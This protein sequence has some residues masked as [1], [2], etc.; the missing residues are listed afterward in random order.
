V[1]LRINHILVP[2]ARDK[3]CVPG[4]DSQLVQTQSA[5]TNLYRILK[6][7]AADEHVLL[8][9]PTAAGKTSLVRYLAYLTEH[10][11]RYI[12]IHSETGTEEKGD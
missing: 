4:K 7:I 12:N 9:G 3:A 10:N 6:A 1:G 11:M 2:K 5:L 8:S